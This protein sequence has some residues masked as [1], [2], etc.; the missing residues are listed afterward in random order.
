MRLLSAALQ[1]LLKYC[2]RVHWSSFTFN[3]GLK[4]VEKIRDF[5]LYHNARR[6]KTISWGKIVLKLK[7]EVENCPGITLRV[8]FLESCFMM[9]SV[10]SIWSLMTKNWTIYEVFL[11]KAKELSSLLSVHDLI[12]QPNESF[13]TKLKDIQ[14]VLNIFSNR[15]N[16]SFKIA[17]YVLLNSTLECDS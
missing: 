13:L 15:I 8:G 12:R 10:L 2:D 9:K 6:M 14:I 3:N 4:I 17:F 1:A 5:R 16:D 7:I 11:F